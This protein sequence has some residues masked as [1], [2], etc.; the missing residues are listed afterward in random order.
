MQW[1]GTRRFAGTKRPRSVLRC[2]DPYEFL[3]SIHRAKK[4]VSL[5]SRSSPA[6]AVTVARFG[7]NA[8]AAGS[9]VAVQ[10]VGVDE[11]WM[12]GYDASYVAVTTKRPR[13]CSTVPEI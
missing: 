8:C 9:L 12:V 1:C 13:Y 6:S 11:Q 4:S 7:R 2:S 3:S 10:V 5:Y